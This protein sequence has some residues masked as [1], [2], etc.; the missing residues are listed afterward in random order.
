[1]PAVGKGLTGGVTADASQVVIFGVDSEANAAVYNLD[2]ASRLWVKYL[3]RDGPSP[4]EDSGLLVQSLNPGTK[5]L[6]T[7]ESEGAPLL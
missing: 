4:R 3:V 2:M 1:M 7:G 6:P 5:V